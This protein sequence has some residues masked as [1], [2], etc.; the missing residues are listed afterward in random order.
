MASTNKTTNYDLSQYIGTDK[1]T[2][3]VDYNQDMAKIDAGITGAKNVAD[4]NAVNIGDLDDLSTTSKADLVNAINEVDSD[5]ST[6]SSQVGDNT[7]DIGTLQGN[8]GNLTN[9]ETT[10]KNN[11]VSA[12]N[13]VNGKADDNSSDIATN[14]EAIG[15][16]SNLTTTEKSNLVVAI[17]EVNSELVGEVIFEGNSMGTINLSKSI[18]NFK[19][20]KILVGT[21]NVP[22]EEFEF[23]VNNQNSNITLC[24]HYVSNNKLYVYATDYTITGQTMTPTDYIRGDI[25]NLVHDTNFIYVYKVEGYTI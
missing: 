22:S 19:R 17:N 12:I 24:R 16:L 10:A 14:T 13:E 21:G 25:N 2:Y 23:Y 9:L 11:L 6:V 8:V 18:T 20:I 4:A 15:T 3:L 5:L 7:S 1:P